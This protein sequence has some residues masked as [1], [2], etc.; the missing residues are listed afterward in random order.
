M[1]WFFEN[2]WKI[3]VWTIRAIDFRKKV[4]VPK[5]TDFLLALSSVYKT[6]PLS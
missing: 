6:N 2:F 4:A 5:G 1:Q 3:I